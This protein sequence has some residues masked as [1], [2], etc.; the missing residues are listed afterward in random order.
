MKEKNQKTRM[1]FR[2]PKEVMIKGELY[3]VIVK[4]DLKDDDGHECD[5]LHDHEKKIIYITTGLK[6]DYR[7]QTFL[8]EFFHAYLHEC[9]VREGLDS[10]LEEVIVE[11]LS[12]AT[13][14]HLDW[15]WK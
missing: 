12:Q 10:Q 3:K 9:H 8:H 4:K 15:T 1:K 2:L 11:C 13:D 7:R 14:K 6:H 5:G